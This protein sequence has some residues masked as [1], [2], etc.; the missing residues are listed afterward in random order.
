[1]PSRK[2]QTTSQRP[3]VTLDIDQTFENSPTSEPTT[4]KRGVQPTLYGSMQK[5]T[6]SSIMKMNKNVRDKILSPEMIEKINAE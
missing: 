5:M 1:V 2:G 3:D 4:P 6:I